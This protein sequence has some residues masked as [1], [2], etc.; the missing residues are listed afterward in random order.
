[1]RIALAASV[2]L[3]VFGA[4]RTFELSGRITPELRASVSLHGATTAFSSSTLAERGRFRFADLQPGSYTLIVFVPGRGEI[5]QTIEVGPGTANE[6]GRVEI[7]VPFDDA[8]ATPDPGTVSARDLSIPEQAQKEYR[9][10]QKVLGKRDTAKAIEHLKRAVEIA[11]RFAQAWNNL[12]TIAYHEQRYEDAA[13]FFRRALEADPSAYEPLVNLGGVLINL[14]NLD[15]AYT[16]N[17]HAILRRPNDPLANAQFG[18]TYLGMGKLQLAEKYL[19]EA[20]RLD[21]AHFS[22]PQLLL[23]EIYLREKRFAESATQ[24]EE[25]LKYHPDSPNARQMRENIAKLRRISPA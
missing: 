7:E 8:R 5:R 25:F 21:P 23:A 10:A 19:L 1:M 24:L 22:N 15:E 11:P 2:A 13:G 6:K 9:K 4:E 18:M 3:A 12:G 20:R 16:F 17:L 14:N